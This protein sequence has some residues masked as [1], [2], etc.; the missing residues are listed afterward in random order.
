MVKPLLLLLC[1]VVLS[2]SLR[3]QAPRSDTAIPQKL[4]LK[5]ADTGFTKHP[6]Y[7]TRKRTNGET[8]S[9]RSLMYVGPV[10]KDSMNLRLPPTKANKVD[11]KVRAGNRIRFS[12][13]SNY[14]GSRWI[15]AIMQRALPPPLV[16]IVV[17]GE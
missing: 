3:A 10:R 2:F 11:I 6:V 5:K 14:T 13:G 7:F 16:S 9:V 4:E 12:G 1:C 15:S 17:S 8:D